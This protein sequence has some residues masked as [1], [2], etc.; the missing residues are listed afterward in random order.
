M[1][2]PAGKL[3]RQTTIRIWSEAELLCRELAMETINQSNIIGNFK[4][5]LEEGIK[6]RRM[7]MQQ[8]KDQPEPP[9]TL[10]DG[11]L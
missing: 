4:S 11:G 7:E 3:E 5:S 6:A 9:E 10:K 1:P 8:Q 2:S